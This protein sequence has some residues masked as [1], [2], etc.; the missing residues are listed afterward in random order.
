ME[1]FV[2]QSFNLLFG[3]AFQTIPLILLN[4]LKGDLRRNFDNKEFLDG[5]ME[6]IIR[7]RFLVL[8][9]ARI[10]FHYAFDCFELRIEE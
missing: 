8:Q 3:D 5:E 1:T 6:D 7:L 9:S 2:Y 10:A 4:I